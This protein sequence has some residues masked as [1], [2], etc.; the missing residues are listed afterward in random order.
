MSFEDVRQILLDWRTLWTDIQ[1]YHFNDPKSPL[2]H[3][4]LQ[5]SKTLKEIANFIETHEPTLRQWMNEYLA[6]NRHI[7]FMKSYSNLM[8]LWVKDQ[9]MENFPKRTLHPEIQKSWNSIFGKDHSMCFE[10]AMK[11]F[12]HAKSRIPASRHGYPIVGFLEQSDLCD[13]V[14]EGGSLMCTA[15]GT[16]DDPIILALHYNKDCNSDGWNDCYHCEEQTDLWKK[17][18]LRRLSNSP[19]PLLNPEARKWYILGRWSHKSK[20]L[21]QEYPDLPDSWQPPH[22]W[23]R[24]CYHNASDKCYDFDKYINYVQCS[25]SHFASKGMV[26]V[27]A[28]KTLL[29]YIDYAAAWKPHHSSKDFSDEYEVFDLLWNSLDILKE[30]LPLGRNRIEEIEAMF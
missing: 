9:I 19:H 5:L 4:C 28:T 7:I 3:N 23:C 20:Y 12:R 8:H 22:H 10:L 18:L 17:E 14:N 6:A 30:S 16:C 27:E 1:M 2:Y 15:C 25:L 26:P 24:N 11:A 29:V 21:K 13:R